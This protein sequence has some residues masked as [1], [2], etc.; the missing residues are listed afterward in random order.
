[1]MDRFSSEQLEYFQDGQNDI[2]GNQQQGLVGQNLNSYMPNSPYRFGM[3]GSSVPSQNASPFLFSP[4][5]TYSEQSHAQNLSN[6]PAQLRVST[7]SSTFPPLSYHQSPAIGLMPGLPRTDLSPDQS[8]FGDPNLL[9]ISSSTGLSDTLSTPVSGQG[10][11]STSNN[12]SL[13]PLSLPFQTEPVNKQTQPG[14]GHA[15]KRHATESP[16][17]GR[18]RQ[19]HN[20]SEPENSVHGQNMNKWK[21][22][23]HGQRENR[24]HGVHNS[25]P[26]PGLEGWFEDM[27]KASWKTTNRSPTRECLSGI[28]KS[29]NLSLEMVE[30]WTHKLCMDQSIPSGVDP[31]LLSAHTRNLNSPNRKRATSAP[32]SPLSGGVVLDH[33][34]RTRLEKYVLDA[35]SKDCKKTSRNPDGMFHCTWNCGYTTNRTDDWQKH[36]EIRQPQKF[37]IC[38][39]CSREEANIAHRDD[40]MVEHLVAKHKEDLSPG[41]PLDSKGLKGL[42]REKLPTMHVL[43]YRESFILR[44]GFGGYKFKSWDDRNKHLIAHFR[45]TIEPSSAFPANW[46]MPWPDYMSDGCKR[47]DDASPTMRKGKNAAPSWEKGDPGYSNSHNRT[48][49]E[50]NPAFPANSTEHNQLSSWVSEDLSFMDL[51]GTK[52]ESST[53]GL[54]IL[55]QNFISLRTIAKLGTGVT[56]EVDKVRAEDGTEYARKM[57]KNPRRRPSI[58]QRLVHE[59]HIMRSMAHESLVTFVALVQEGERLYLLM[60]PAAELDLE[61]FLRGEE[62]RVA[63]ESSLID[64]CS[65]AAEGL[66]YMHRHQVYHRDLKPANI[67]V[68]NRKLLLADFGLSYRSKDEVKSSIRNAPSPMYAAPEAA[69]GSPHGM[70]SD[71]FSLGCVF[72][73]VLAVRLGESV[74]DV[75]AALGMSKDTGR[76]ATYREKIGE[77][78]D[79][80]SSRCSPQELDRKMCDLARAMMDPLPQRR[81][82]ATQVLETLHQLQVPGLHGALEN[83]PGLVSSPVNSEETGAVQSLGPSTWWTIKFQLQNYFLALSQIVRFDSHRISHGPGN[84]IAFGNDTM[85]SYPARLLDL[86][87]YTPEEERVRLVLASMVKPSAA[88]VAL[89]HIWSPSDEICTTRQSLAQFERA[90]H[91]NILPLKVQDALRATV[92]MGWRYLWVDTLCIVQDDEKER[93]EAVLKMSRIYS[94]A[95]AVIIAISELDSP[96]GA[97]DSVATSTLW[98][99]AKSKPFT[100]GS[101]TLVHRSKETARYSLSQASNPTASVLDRFTVNV[102]SDPQNSSSRWWMIQKTPI[103]RSIQST[104]CGPYPHKPCRVCI[105]RRVRRATRLLQTLARLVG[106]T[107]GA[108]RRTHLRQKSITGEASP[109]AQVQPSPLYTDVIGIGGGDCGGFDDSSLFP[110]RRDFSGLGVNSAY[111]AYV[112]AP[113]PLPPSDEDEGY[114]SASEH[115]SLSD[116]DLMRD[117]DEGTDLGELDNLAP[118]VQAELRACIGIGMYTMPVATASVDPEHVKWWNLNDVSS[119]VSTIESSV[120]DVCDL[121]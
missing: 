103:I 90:I 18:K 106:Q 35:Q 81:P 101:F 100:S 89:S 32:S 49:S 42:A 78:M 20:V 58:M 9:S 111:G 92:R 12:S 13:P 97:N 61:Q 21:Q 15:M 99:P 38:Q 26:P 41:K 2:D 67:L 56:A 46:L 70:Q 102:Q 73:E 3:P 33:E 11:V 16:A 66:S 43:Q 98:S 48:T 68:H 93:Q 29:F 54:R 7:P 121:I 59:S 45:G 4:G 85:Q 25:Q 72:L 57:V 50:G 79:W 94:S 113:N 5:P 83:H 24:Q 87:Q 47:R 109:G 118:D 119:W 28:A 14:L 44:C 104:S 88:Y 37:W 27:V 55:D 107:K 30:V 75:H 80:I 62:S 34:L 71:V 51:G 120:S 1:M 110:T 95:I 84:P 52:L 77:I 115:C 108:A 17:E 76:R 22:R 65:S 53:A 63:L 82:T 116:R 19:K 74:G 112:S 91:W 36:E 105:G 69:R 114:L 117:L 40:K 64:L 8:W 39:F 10:T 23:G 60:T 86:S 6:V 96:T 31:T